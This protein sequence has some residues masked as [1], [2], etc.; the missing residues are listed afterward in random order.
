MLKNERSR[1]GLNR[2]YFFGLT[3]RGSSNFALDLSPIWNVKLP[4]TAIKK[5]VFETYEIWIAVYKLRFLHLAGTLLEGV[6][7]EWWRLLWSYC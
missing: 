3:I 1:T 5:C 6:T 4:E 7:V 2:Q